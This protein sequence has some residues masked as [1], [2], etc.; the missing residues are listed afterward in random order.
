MPDR[1]LSWLY[2]VARAVPEERG[3]CSAIRWGREEEGCCQQETRQEGK[4]QLQRQAP[5]LLCQGFICL[6]EILTLHHHHQ[7][8]NTGSSQQPLVPKGP[9]EQTV[10]ART[11]RK[12]RILFWSGDSAS[13]DGVGDW[14]A[15][16][17]Q[18]FFFSST[19]FSASELENREERLA[20]D[21]Q[22]RGWKEKR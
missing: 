21:I 19:P 5:H 18:I 10:T 14:I 13:L 22:G 9:K 7:P 11:H 17:L 12:E 1:G 4:L 15:G 8:G 16:D 3:R 6:Q 2:Q 20:L